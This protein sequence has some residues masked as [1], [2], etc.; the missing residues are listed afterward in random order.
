MK[1]LNNNCVQFSAGLHLMFIKQQD[2]E[3]TI[4]IPKPC[5]EDWNAMLP[6]AQGKHCLSCCKTVIDFSTWETEDILTYLQKRNTEQ[7]CGRFNTQQVAI[8]MPAREELLENVVR[9]HIPLLRKIAAVIVVCFGLLYTVDVQAQEQ[10]H[11]LG[12]PAYVHIQNTIKGEPALAD[13]AKVAADTTYRSQIMGMIAM[14]PKEIHK[15]KKPVKG[16]STIKRKTK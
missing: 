11:L 3:N 8:E 1:K 13:T 4:S 6:E 2:M 12:K 15:D 5:H 10:Q 7:V 9:A 14:P 16:K